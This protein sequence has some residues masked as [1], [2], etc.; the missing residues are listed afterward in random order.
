MRYTSNCKL[1]PYTCN[2]LSLPSRIAARIFSSSFGSEAIV[3]RAEIVLRCFAREL[4]ACSV[5]TACCH[6][7]P[8]SPALIGFSPI[9][10]V[11]IQNPGVSHR[12]IDTTTK[13]TMEMSRSALL[14]MK[15]TLTTNTSGYK[16]Y[17][18]YAINFV[19]GLCLLTT[20]VPIISLLGQNSSSEPPRRVFLIPR[21]DFFSSGHSSS[22]F[23][24]LVDPPRRNPSSESKALSS[25]SPSR[26]FPSSGK[27]Y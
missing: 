20:I 14:W 24:L 12:T 22:G 9:Q 26:R 16:K 10:T 6:A 5:L 1:S 23:A 25:S 27:Y 2:G 11:Q 21:R 7:I 13:I 17:I 15:Y 8:A 18:D 3:A 4:T 19:C